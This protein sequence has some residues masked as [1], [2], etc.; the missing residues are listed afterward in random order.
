MNQYEIIARLGEGAF[1]TVYK[2][3]RK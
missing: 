2:V 1:S 3:L